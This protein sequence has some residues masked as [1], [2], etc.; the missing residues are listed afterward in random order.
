MPSIFRVSG[1]NPD[2]GL[3][4]ESVCRV[5]IVPHSLHIKDIISKRS[6]RMVTSTKGYILSSL[7][8]SPFF[9]V[10]VKCRFPVCPIPSM[11]RLGRDR[12]VVWIYIYLCNRC[13]SPLML[14]V[15]TQLMEMCTTLCDKVCQWLA[16]GRWFSLV[17]SANKTDHHDITEIFI[18]SGVKHHK[19]NPNQPIPSSSLFIILYIVELVLV[20]NIQ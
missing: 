4:S 8:N 10:A 3:Y 13:R 15:R 7:P 19:T 5:S 20:L 12:M 14:W 17:S 6:G 18:E 16:A 1:Y 9:L 2:F 11:G